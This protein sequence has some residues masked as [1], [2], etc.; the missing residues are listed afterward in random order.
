M[1]DDQLSPHLDINL[2]TAK[3]NRNVFANS[4]EIAMPVGHILVCDAGCDIEHNDTALTLDV[5]TVSE[6]TKFLLASGIPDIKAD[7]AKVGG[8]L[9][10]MDLYTESG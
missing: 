1:Q 8:K 3:D 10:R 2:V 9:K 4:F 7:C 5:V 6:T